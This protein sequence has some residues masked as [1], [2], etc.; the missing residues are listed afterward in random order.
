MEVTAPTGPTSR[1][2]PLR[3][4][5]R[6]ASPLQGLCRPFSRVRRVGRT[7]VGGTVPQGLLLTTPH[8]VAQ[9]RG[10]GGAVPGRD[11]QACRGMDSP[12]TRAPACVSALNAPA[13]VVGVEVAGP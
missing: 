6:R 4:W 13:G 3:V 1:R 8:S 11:F 7:G 9:R 2:S 12:L 5:S 10:V